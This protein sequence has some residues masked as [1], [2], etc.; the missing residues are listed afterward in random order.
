VGNLECGLTLLSKPRGSS[1]AHSCS[2]RSPFH[3]ESIDAVEQ[4]KTLANCGG[5]KALDLDVWPDF[6]RSS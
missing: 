6:V 5:K 4:R 1:G 2:P 3:P